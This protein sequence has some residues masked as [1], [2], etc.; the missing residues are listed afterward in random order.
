MAN[1]MAHSLWAGQFI[2]AGDENKLFPQEFYN[3]ARDRKW[4]KILMRCVKCF[5]KKSAGYHE[6][7]GNRHLTTIGVEDREGFLEK[8]TSPAETWMSRKWRAD[9]ESVPDKGK[10]ILRDEGIQHFQRM[11]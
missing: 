7:I 1:I 8:V 11:L 4:I 10:Y 3:L 5:G 9:R 2:E 6:D